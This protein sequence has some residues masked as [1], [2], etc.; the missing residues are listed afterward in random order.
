MRTQWWCTLAVVA[1]CGGSDPSASAV[2]HDPCA[3]LAIDAA[4]LT[5]AEQAGVID[6]LALWRGH[7][8]TAMTLADGAAPAAG[9][10]SGGGG[11]DATG[12]PADAAIALRFEDAAA[13][14]HG[15]Y[16]PDSASVLINR[17]LTGDADRAQLAIVIAHELGHV[18][19]LVHIDP[20]VRLSLM[21]PGNL[22][23]TPTDADQQALADLWGACPSAAAP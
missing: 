23:T 4:S 12:A 2:A 10:A 1:A 16:D 9:A 13:T 18:F 6:A 21:N 7:G 17:D 20:A 19:G 15:V 3:P 22:V 5:D 14:F 8:I 11:N